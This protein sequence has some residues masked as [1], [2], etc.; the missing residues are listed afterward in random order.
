MLVRIALEASA[1]YL[2]ERRLGHIAPNWMILSKAEHES[3]APSYIGFWAFLSRM[4][5]QAQN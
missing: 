4:W 5:K 3:N 1:I 2:P